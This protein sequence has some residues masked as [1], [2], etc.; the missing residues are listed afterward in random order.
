M[1]GFLLP[2]RVCAGSFNGAGMA[3][4]NFEKDSAAVTLVLEAGV[5]LVLVP[6]ECT[7]APSIF[8]S[9]TDLHHP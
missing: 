5:S 9:G 6:F 4:M 1:V 3:D 7:G 8:R 2:R